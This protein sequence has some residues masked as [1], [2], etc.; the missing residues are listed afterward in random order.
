[1]EANLAN[2]PREPIVE[3]DQS[4]YLAYPKTQIPTREKD[5]PDRVRRMLQQA[6]EVMIRANV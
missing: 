1:M 4:S 2:G 3:L 5:E 6:T